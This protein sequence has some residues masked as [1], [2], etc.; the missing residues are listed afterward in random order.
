MYIWD[1]LIRIFW[2]NHESKEVVSADTDQLI[3]IVCCMFLS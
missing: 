1:A 2:A 3:L